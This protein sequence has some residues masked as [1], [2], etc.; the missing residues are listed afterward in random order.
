M[1]SFGCFLIFLFLNYVFLSSS[2]AG[3][4]INEINSDNPTQPERNEFIELI[5]YDRAEGQSGTKQQ[6]TYSLRGYKIVVIS[7]Y[8][9]VTKSPTVELVANLWN[10]KITNSFFVFGGT[11]VENADLK[12]DSPFVTYR[13]KFAKSATFLD[14]SKMQTLTRTLLLY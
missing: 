3:V 1:V 2:Y 4:L 12:V 10:S 5:A 11:N 8:N 7:V 6:V 14:F 13:H 9:P